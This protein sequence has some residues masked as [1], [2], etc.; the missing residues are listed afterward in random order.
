MHTQS[1]HAHCM[2]VHYTLHLHTVTEH[3]CK[4]CNAAAHWQHRRCSS[5]TLTRR[6]LTATAA[7]GWL[8]GWRTANSAQR[9]AGAQACRLAHERATWHM[10]PLQLGDACVDGRWGRA[11]LCVSR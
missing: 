3:G 10:S 8:A 5:L 1:M 9:L 6:S 4:L 2:H 11:V 7:G